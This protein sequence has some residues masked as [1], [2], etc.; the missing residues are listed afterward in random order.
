MIK[1]QNLKKIYNGTTVLDIESLDIAPG[2]LVGLVGNNGAGKTTLLR[3]V[4]D[5]IKADDGFV[6]SDG[7]K[8]NESEDWKTYTG[9]Y[10]DGRFL[11]DFLTPEE[12]FSFIGDVY[13]ID[14]ETM[15]ERLAPFE[16]FMH[17]EI[18]ETRSIC[19]ISHRATARK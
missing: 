19:V 1:I 8:V 7:K 10:I 2:E 12:Y 17:D 6:E 14:E 11:V 3:L 4:L 16:T 18:M 9:S 13:G 15:K 5:L